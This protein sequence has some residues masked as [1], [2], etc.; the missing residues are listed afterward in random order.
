M[1]LRE[2]R[3]DNFHITSVHFFFCNKQKVIDHTKLYYKTLCEQKLGVIGGIRWLFA[4]DY[5]Q[6]RS[7]SVMVHLNAVWSARCLHLNSLSLTQ[8]LSALASCPISQPSSSPIH[9][10]PSH[11]TQL[12]PT[13]P[14]GW[15]SSHLGNKTRKLPGSSGTAEKLPLPDWFWSFFL[16]V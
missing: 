5:N 3:C 14:L 9:H 2:R 15:A 13:A 7:S 6:N 1:S 4:E 8:Q 10:P 12:L 11:Q 16:P